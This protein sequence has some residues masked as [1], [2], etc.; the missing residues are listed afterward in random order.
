MSRLASLSIQLQEKTNECETLKLADADADGKLDKAELVAIQEKMSEDARKAREDIE[1]KLIAAVNEASELRKKL[2][3]KEKLLA[4][5]ELGD[6]AVTA[7]LQQTIEDLEFKNAK[8]KKKMFLIKE[9]YDE[10]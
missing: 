9:E 10:V 3:S 8:Q 7:E 6:K 4:S 1:Q 2:D 5:T